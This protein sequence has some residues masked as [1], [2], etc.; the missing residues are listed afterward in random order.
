L[1]ALHFATDKDAEESHDGVVWSVDFVRLHQRLPDKFKDALDRTGGIAFT[2]EL[3][4]STLTTVTDLGAF[5]ENFML[6]FEPP[7]LD[8]RVVQQYA[9]LSVMASM[10]ETMTE[11]LERQPD[12]IAQKVRVPSTLKRQVRER[13]DQANVNE[14]SLFPGLDGLSTWLRRYYSTPARTP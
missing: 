11:W 4:S 9:S 13:L 6:V 10:D 5:G 14:R 12:E 7:S 8:D 2:P 1:V 3:L